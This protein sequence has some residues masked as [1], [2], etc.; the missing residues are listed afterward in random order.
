MAALVGLA[1]LAVAASRKSRWVS[2]ALAG[3]VGLG[4]V[5]F[6]AWIGIGRSFGRLTSTFW[7]EVARGGRGMVWWESREL[8]IGR[9]E[10]R[11]RV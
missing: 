7:F 11:E 10:R 3:A 1:V 6:L 9:G 8:Q 2:V 5:S 4:S